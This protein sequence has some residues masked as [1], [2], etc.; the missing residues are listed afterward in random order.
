MVQREIFN[1]IR[2]IRSPMKGIKCLNSGKDVFMNVNL[3][4]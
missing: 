4:V 3:C 1:L 2:G